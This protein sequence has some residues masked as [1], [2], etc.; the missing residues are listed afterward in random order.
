MSTFT[1]HVPSGVAGDAARADATVFVREGFDGGAFLLGPLALLYRG[2]WLGTLAWAVAAAA[3]LA[4]A[5][6]SGLGFWPRLALYLVLATLT[7]LEAAEERRRALGRAG[8]IPA[9]LVAGPTRDAAERLFFGAAAP[10]LEPVPHR[11]AARAGGPRPVIG[12]FPASGGR[13]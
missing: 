6:L 7:G 13:A 9:A 1:V 2:L 10:L 4:V 11:P 5:A 8:F 3:L 12:L